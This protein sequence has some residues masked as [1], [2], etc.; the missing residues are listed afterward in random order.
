MKMVEQARTNLPQKPVKAAA[1]AAAP[2][3][4]G[5]GGKARPKEE[6]NDYEE[7]VEDSRPPSSSSSKTTVAGGAKGKAK[8]NGA[9][10]AASGLAKKVTFRNLLSFYWVLFRILYIHLEV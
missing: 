4:K 3:V 10:P 2:V 7:D 8:P 9:A 5:G 6:V 1:P